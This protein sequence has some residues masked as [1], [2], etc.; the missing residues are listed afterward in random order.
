MK[1]H[2][3][4]VLNNLHMFKCNP[5]YH[6]DLMR[7]LDGIYFMWKTIEYFQPKS[8]LEIGF[9]CGET[10]GLLVEASG[11][12][13]TRIVSVDISYNN[14][15]SFKK[16]FPTANIEYIEDDSK[17]LK[18]NEKFDFINIDGDHSYT[19]ASYDIKN[20]LSMTTKDTIICIDD[21][22]FQEVDMAIKNHL[23]E[24]QSDFVPFL[25]STQQIYFHHRSHSA[26]VFLDCFL[27][28]N[29]PRFFK[30]HNKEYYG[31]TI[32][33]GEMYDEMFK[34]DPEIF[35]LALKYSDL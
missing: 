24:G 7:D 12:T 11:S 22:H 16:L 8:I 10:L 5:G 13:C 15:S 33:Y 27:I 35:R 32:T 9:G 31:Y 21:Y 30:Y 4:C 18:L 20:C 26:D 17:N 14:T 28:D 29:D 19:Q 6:L 2:Q 23:I 25:A 3:S 34:N 1:L